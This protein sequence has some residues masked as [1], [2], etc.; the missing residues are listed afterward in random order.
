MYLKAR[1]IS[2]VYFQIRKEKKNMFYFT[3][4]SIVLRGKEITQAVLEGRQ[5]RNDNWIE[6]LH[7]W[8]IYI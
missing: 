1:D 8:Y 3:L 4:L 5:K 7:C 2:Y 6:L